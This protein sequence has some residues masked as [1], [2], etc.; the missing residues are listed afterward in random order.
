MRYSSNVVAYSRMFC[1]KL[2]LILTLTFLSFFG[3]TPE[4]W[5]KIE[6]YIPYANLEIRYGFVNENGEW[7]IEP[8]YQSGRD[9]S[10]GFAFVHN[11]GKGFYINERNEIL[12]KVN[13]DSGEDFGPFGALVFE[14]GYA[15][16]ITSGGAYIIKPKF[17]RAY[18]IVNG[19]A[20]VNEYGGSEYSYINLNSL[21]TII[22]FS[23]IGDINLNFTSGDSSLL[24]Y[25]CEEGKWGFINEVGEL[26][27]PCEYDAVRNFSEGKAGVAKT[28]N[29]GELL[30]TYIDTTGKTTGSY[31][32][33]SVYDYKYGLTS[34]MKMKNNTETYL[35]L[36][37]KGYKVSNKEYVAQP[38]IGSEYTFV[39]EN[40]DEG[41]YIGPNK[42]IVKA[43]GKQITQGCPFQNGKF[44]IRTEGSTDSDGQYWLSESGGIASFI[45]DTNKIPKGGM[46]H[47]IG[48]PSANGLIL[49]G[50]SYQPKLFDRNTFPLPSFSFLKEVF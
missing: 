39:M 47:T 33:S 32:Y 35:L 16:Y 48:C 41:Y 3:C 21:E 13:F 12:G 9:F 49:V 4:I 7:V 42:K 5:E 46:V 36:D 18:P 19:F 28:Q 30:W 2:F 31:D 17:V 40:W 15:G 27:L 25:F 22:N 24:P 8:V 14:A 50:V 10:N 26:K 38:E 37:D 43:S 45:I 6:G 23:Y 34:V 29:S 44:L 11:K 1:N 20:L